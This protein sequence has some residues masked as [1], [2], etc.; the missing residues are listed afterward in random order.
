[1]RLIQE[2]L[3]SLLRYLTAGATVVERHTRWSYTRYN[4]PRVLSS[5]HPLSRLWCIR[6]CISRG[7]TTR[8]KVKR[9]EFFLPPLSSEPCVF[10]REEFGRPSPSSI[11]ES[12]LLCYRGYYNKKSQQINSAI[13]TRPVVCNTFALVADSRAIHPT[14]PG[15]NINIWLSQVISGNRTL[16][17]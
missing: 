11:F 7:H 13:R 15:T 8:E 10:G 6:W 1:M 5:L 4:F 9:G 3:P 16:V 14:T 2:A 17:W 12:N